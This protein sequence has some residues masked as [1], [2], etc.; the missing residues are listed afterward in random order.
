MTNPLSLK[1]KQL[2]QATQQLQDVLDDEGAVHILA[3]DTHDARRRPPNMLEGYEFAAKRVGSIEAR[4][5]VL[6]RPQG[7]LANVPP[8]N[9]PMPESRSCG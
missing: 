6:T 3:P 7:I 9:L 8:S 1:V 2:R 4:H 5:L